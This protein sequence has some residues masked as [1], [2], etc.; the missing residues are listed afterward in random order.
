MLRAI[1]LAGLWMLSTS[2]VAGAPEVVVVKGFVV[3]VEPTRLTISNV[4]LTAVEVPRGAGPTFTMPKAK[5]GEQAPKWVS[6]E[7]AAK[8]PAEAAP[9]IRMMVTGPGQQGAALQLTE[10]ELGDAKVAA[11]DYPA[12]TAV[13]VS[14]RLVE[15]RKRLE[16]LERS[17]PPAQ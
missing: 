11:V 12:G 10:I 6:A 9:K 14:F 15:G 7:P 13:D 2:A 8:A 4:P 3:A 16:K 1:A 17:A 5:E